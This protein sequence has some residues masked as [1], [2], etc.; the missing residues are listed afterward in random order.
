MDPTYL[1][2]DGCYATND[3]VHAALR[4]RIP[5]LYI[6]DCDVLAYMRERSSTNAADWVAMPTY[7]FG[8]YPADFA[9]LNATNYNY[10]FILDYV[11][12]VPVHTNGVY[13][14]YGFPIYITN[15]V[16]SAGFRGTSAKGE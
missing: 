11:P 6:D 12:P 8:A 9:V 5:E 4:S 7:A 3:T 14:L 1:V 2:D 16:F 15:D 13:N 10:M